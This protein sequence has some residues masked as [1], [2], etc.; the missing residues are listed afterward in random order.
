MLASGVPAAC[1][2]KGPGLTP[3]PFPRLEW[4]YGVGVSDR[5][6]ERDGRA[7]AAI[8]GPSL[9]LR[10]VPPTPWGKVGLVRSAKE[11]TSPTASAPGAGVERHGQVQRHDI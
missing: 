10:L 3:A 2:G 8:P 1:G 4:C 5:A 11:G 7:G 9:V 6:P